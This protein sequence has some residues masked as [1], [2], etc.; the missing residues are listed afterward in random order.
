MM[1]RF[2]LFACLLLTLNSCKDDFTLEGDFQDIPTAYAYLDAE[3]SRHFIR[4]QKA[5]L[6]SGGNAITNAGIA[7]SVYY[8]PEDATVILRNVTTGNETT[9]ERV[10]ARDFGRN[11]ADGVFTNDPN[12]AYSV[13]DAD[14]PLNPRDVIEV[15][16]ERP[17]SETATA[18]TTMLEEIEILRPGSQV[19]VD[20]P[21]RPLIM[22][23]SK[24]D[25][26]SIYDV[27]VIFN[28]RELFPQ[29]ASMNRDIT[30]TWQVANAYL[31]GDNATE[32][33]VRF[34]VDPE[35]FY[36]FLQANL[37]VNP[38][39]VRRF[40]DFDVQVAA[41]GQEVADLRNLQNANT[42]ITS[43]GALPRYTNLIGGI[44]L[45]T[46]S[47]RSLKEGIGFDD[48]S[49]DSLR[50]GQFTRELGFQ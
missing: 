42:G 11:R 33:Q 2:F 24:G 29:D 13:T 10:D 4:V 46:S 47:T 22:S 7:D 17:G 6:E 20:N 26:A 16:I 30:L 12:I 28:I 15:L 44:G 27:R 1:H 48:N 9:M 32:S 37:E 31:P 18:T 34:E 50:D 19:R 23:W 39:V 25:A 21:G 41:A 45:I 43:S 3:D 5:F 8:G 36:R 40:Q 14:L 38:N 35:G 49:I